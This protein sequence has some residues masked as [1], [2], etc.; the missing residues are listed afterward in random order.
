MG[1]KVSEIFEEAP[2]VP[3]VKRDK[4]KDVKPVLTPE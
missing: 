1:R 2:T 3:I 4:E